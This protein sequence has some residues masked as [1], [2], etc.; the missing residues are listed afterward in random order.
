MDALTLWDNAFALVVFLLFPLYSR[1][2]ISRALETIRQGGEAIR[3]AAYQKV[4]MTWAGFAV[5]VGLFWVYFGRSFADLGISAS[6]GQ[7]LVV[8]SLVAA[9]VVALIVVPI[10]R[11]AANP[12]QHDELMG[13]LGDVALFMPR[14][15]REERW[16]NGVSLNAGIS[17]EL[18]FRGYLIWYLQHFVSTGWA[19]GIAVLAFAYAHWYQGVKQLP[20]I[21][22]VSG[23]AVSLY[24][25]TGSLLVPIVFHVVLDAL[26]GRYIARIRRSEAQA[27]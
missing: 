24:L 25:Y 14:S 9:A 20:G 1:M 12:A 23:V 6:G 5:C 27:A 26:Q 16:F 17:E 4:I 19:A 2:T 8:G 22:F 15:R 3:V 10:R 7:K 21:L 11:V 13:Q 18:I